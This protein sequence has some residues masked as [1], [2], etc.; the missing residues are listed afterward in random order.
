MCNCRKTLCNTKQCTCKKTSAFC[1]EQCG[2]PKELCQNRPEAEDASQNEEAGASVKA[3][4]WADVWKSLDKEREL[5]QLLSQF[6]VIPKRLKE[7]MEKRKGDFDEMTA[8]LAEMNGL[9]MA[10]A[11]AEELTEDEWKS[12]EQQLVQCS[13]CERR[14][15]PERIEKHE[16]ICPKNVLK[17]T[18][19]FLL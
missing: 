18:V 16:G 3:L 11:N 17:K 9:T 2:C 6:R 4:A 13:K 10:N 8:L 14:F 12:F 7:I 1:S 15:H 5:L 19:T